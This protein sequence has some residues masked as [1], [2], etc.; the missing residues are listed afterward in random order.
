MNVI[1]DASIVNNAEI[2]SGVWQLEVEAP[3]ICAEYTGPGQFISL[4]T[5]D[6]WEHP[7]RRPM[8]IAA[9]NGSHLSIIYKIFGDVT[10]SLTKK[11]KGDS[12][13]LLGPL[14]NTF[15][16]WDNLNNHPILIGGGVGLAPM[17]NLKNACNEKNIETTVI[18][19][20]KTASEHFIESDH[21]KGIYLTTD[22]GSIGEKGTVIPVLELLASKRSNAK[23]FA[24]GPEPMLK[25]LKSFSYS[26][27]IS[28]EFSV[29]S[30]MACGLGL[31]Q[32]CVIEKSSKNGNKPSYHEQFSLVCIDGP[33][34]K[35]S[36]VHFA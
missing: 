21:D 25:A 15:S 30:Y 36:E 14:G 10:L 31:C 7:L 24:C 17:L 1:E 8:S 20:A 33:V 18:L 35:A 34:Y 3:H 27:G 4:L 13:N 2:A 6:S 11:T 28:A 5:D 22:D 32:G 26:A 19:G 23:L 12:I 16:G 9:V 29:E